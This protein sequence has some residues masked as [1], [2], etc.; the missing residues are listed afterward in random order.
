MK[1]FQSIKILYSEKSASNDNNTQRIEYLLVLNGDFETIPLDLCSIYC[2]NPSSNHLLDIT[3]EMKC[4]SESIL[5]IKI[6]L[7]LLRDENFRIFLACPWTVK[8]I[9][10]SRA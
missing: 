10:P 7:K 8:E 2:V 1:A 9:F 6:F 4:N 5:E 3:Y